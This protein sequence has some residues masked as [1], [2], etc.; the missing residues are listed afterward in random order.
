V[1]ATLFCVVAAVVLALPARA[2][3]AGFTFGVAAGEIRTTSAILWARAPDGRVTIE[4]S[5]R[6][7]G[8][9]V[10]RAAPVL[11]RGDRTVQAS[12]TGLRTG[13]V[14]FYRFRA[15]RQLSAV[16]RFAT[17]PPATS[18]AP[19]EFAYSGDADATP[20]PATRAPAFNGFGVYA[21]MA[22]EGNDFNVNLGD[23]IYSDAEVGGA[24]AART[25]PEKWA[26]YRLG[27]A[28]PPLRRLRAATGL[29]SHWDDHE[30]VNDFS[31]AEHGEAIYA[32]GV[33][34]FTDYAPVRFTSADGLY[35]T[36]RWGRNL[37]LFFLDERSFRDAKASA[38]GT[39]DNPAT[40]GRPDL[41]PTAPAALRAG[42]AQLAPPLGQ[43]VAPA[44]LER[45]RDLA[46]TL[47]GRRQLDRFLAAVTAS[48]AIFKVIVNEVP[49]QQFYA[50]PYDRWEGYEAER[51]RVLE[52]LRAVPNVVF[53]T[54][55]THATLVGDVRLRTFEPPGPLETGIVEAIAGPVATNTYARELDATLGTTGTG[56]LLEA[57][58]FRPA[59]PRGLGMRCAVTNVYGYA[60]VRVTATELTIT[61]KDASGR[62]LR[63]LSGNPCGSF[64]IPAR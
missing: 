30:F 50:L 18:S 53:M 54:T 13:T 45:L 32:A 22:A 16:G 26:K 8:G 24:P 6:R 29:Y 36:V 55:D 14:Y 51:T 52:T 37:E 59:P 44:C 20:D 28:L 25:V 63:E 17:A 34:A 10:R 31:R 41:A 11:R 39:C 12:I 1:R 5:R 60:Q 4:L 43:P 56:P 57:L 38:G 23:T 21:A 35:R 62:P 3:A 46:R 61:P 47:L 58:L 9:F 64:T 33:K 15:G 27:L 42:F 49:I 7:I 19:V 40:P 48:R 2:Q